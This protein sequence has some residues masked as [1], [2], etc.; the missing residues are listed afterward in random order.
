M[1]IGVFA[2]GCID[3]PPQPNITNSNNSNNTNSNNTNSNNTNS[4]NSNN[5]NS[6]NTN[7][8]NTNS[9]NSSP[10][11]V[12]YS[13]VDNS[14]CQTATCLPEGVLGVPG[15]Y[16]TKVCGADAECPIGTHCGFYGPNG[17]GICLRSCEDDSDCTRE[18]FK[19]YDFELDITNTECWPSGVGAAPLGSRC[20]STLDCSGGQGAIC[21]TQVEGFYEG[22]CSKRCLNSSNCGPNGSC[23][24][25]FCAS[26]TCERE[27]GYALADFNANGEEVCW[28]AGTGAGKIGEPCAGVW[29]CDGGAGA[30][31]MTTSD[32]Y[33]SRGCSA[34]VPCG[35]DAACILGDQGSFCLATCDVTPSCR[36]GYVCFTPGPGEIEP[37]NASVCFQPGD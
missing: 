22:Y 37:E 17:F 13:C 11:E 18:G 26:K 6:N 10:K 32:G 16:C 19:C 23:L 14:D 12:G 9:N 36:E 3:A 27:T 30:F 4:N 29:E 25:G 31:C 21:R 20:E 2:V 1:I 15:G 7:S 35:A 33:C 34:E 8:N 28:L 24:N 5:T